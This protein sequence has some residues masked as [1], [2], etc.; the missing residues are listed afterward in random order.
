M[1]VRH[2]KSEAE[3]QEAADTKNSEGKK[4]K[5]LQEVNTMKQQLQSQVQEHRDEEQRLRK[6]KDQDSFLD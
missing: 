2:T 5:L 1:I 4:E 6:V 3:K